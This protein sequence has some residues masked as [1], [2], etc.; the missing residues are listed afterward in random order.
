MI[1]GIKNTLHSIEECIYEYCQWVMGIVVITY[2]AR[3]VTE[4]F[5]KGGR[6]DLYQNIAMADRF[7]SGQ[8]LYYSAIEASTPYFPGVAFLSIFVGK[9]FGPW[10]DYIM[11]IIASLIGAA[12]FYMLINI[13][14]RLSNNIVLSAAMTFL[15]MTFGFE[16]YRLYMNEFK[17]DSL[18]LLIAI[19][20]I[21]IIDGVETNKYT[22][23]V[24][25]LPMLF[26]LAFVMDITKQQALYVDVALGIYLL[27]TKRLVIKDKALILG[28]LI[29]AGIVD[30]AI[31]FCIPGVEIQAIKNLSAMPYQSIQSILEQMSKTFRSNI[32]LFIFLFIFTYLFLSK[33]IK[34][35]S[36]AEK[37]LIIAMI[38]GCG[39]ILGGWKSGGNTGNYEVAVVSF[40]PFAVM[41]VV[42]IYEEYIVNNKK[43]IVIAVIN[44]MLC[45]VC[46][47]V[48]T[49]V[50]GQIYSVEQKI[51]TDNEVSHYLTENF[52]NETMMYSSNYYMQVARSTV[53]PGM[54]IHSLPMNLQ[55]YWHIREEY[56]ENQ[57]YKYLYVDPSKFERDDRFI[58]TYFGE[59]SD[60]AGALE[61]YYEEIIDTDMPESLKGQLFIAK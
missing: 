9:F 6:W 27:Y 41:V 24:S 5:I 58:L 4:G 18:V 59:V 44:C 60:T 29:A 46:F 51:D 12:F 45:C 32:V 16:N 57:T 21:Y 31:I 33:K 52:G 36:L 1:K 10:R 13:S 37:W 56:L 49:E 40:I 50:R 42:Y 30:I 20:I 53:N 26:L 35:S 48:L 19:F 3:S 23:K 8:G 15:L 39:Q 47:N 55:E 54:D 38:F 61:K 43:R 25:Y 11:L 34:L 2:F 28:S 7:L 14:K 17:A 22:L